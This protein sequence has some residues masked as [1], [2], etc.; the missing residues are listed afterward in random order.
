MD[1]VGRP[2][3]ELERM[4]GV[5]VRYASQPPVAEPE[6]EAID[7]SIDDLAKELGAYASLGVGQVIVALEPITSRSVQRLASATRQFRGG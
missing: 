1:E 3:E 5:T 4:V 7:G 2:H 6:E